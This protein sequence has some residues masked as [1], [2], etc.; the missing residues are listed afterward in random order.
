MIAL[1]NG[2]TVTIL[3]TSAPSYV[4]FDQDYT[5]RADL[6]GN[7]LKLYVGGVLMVSATDSTYSH[8]KIGF[9]G[10]NAIAD[11]GNVLV[12]TPVSAMTSRTV[13]KTSAVQNSDLAFAALFNQTSGWLGWGHGWSW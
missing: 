2:S 6:N 11:L 10:T 9:T 12:T 8:G 3:A 4:Q 1:R 5:V 13:A 7:S